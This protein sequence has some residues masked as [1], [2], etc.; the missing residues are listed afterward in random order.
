MYNPM[1]MMQDF[2]RFMNQYR[3]QNPNQILNN[4]ISSGRVSQAQLNQAQMMAKQMA[5]QF[6][7]FRTMF[8]F[9]K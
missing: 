3:G 5:T 9:Q 8:G 7:Q 4:L 2:P 6:D 1:Q